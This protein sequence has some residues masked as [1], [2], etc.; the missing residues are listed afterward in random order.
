MGGILRFIYGQIPESKSVCFTFPLNGA[1][2]TCYYLIKGTFMKFVFALLIVVF[3]FQVMAA[4]EFILT[5]K[6]IHS[7]ESA[8][9]KIGFD[10]VK[11]TETIELG[12]VVCKIDFAFYLKDPQQE[13]FMLTT[14][15]KVD[16]NSVS[17]G[18]EIKRE[19]GLVNLFAF[20]H[21]C[22]I[23]SNVQH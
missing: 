11:R 8:Q 4:E 10:A 21:M 2:D 3:S 1:L 20:G 6:N 19:N 5:I 12:G 15:M 9:R 14:S 22:S 18:S 16:G 17:T 7:N 23:R 13:I